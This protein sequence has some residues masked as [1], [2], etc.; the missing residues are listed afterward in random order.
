MTAQ[1]TSMRDVARAAGVS[2]ATVSY[3][4]NRGP[5]PVGEATRKRVMSAM[6]HVGYQVGRRGRA[7]TR[8]L[9]IGAIVADATNSFFSQALAGAESVL[10]K[11]GHILVAASSNDDAARELKALAAFSRA[12]VDGLI[13]TPRGDVPAE[14]ERLRSRGIPVVLMD[15]DGGSTELNRV[16]MDN[17]G[18]AFQATRLLIES[19][20]HRIALVNGP[21][22][23]STAR[24]RLR[25][26]RDA[27]EQA[28]LVF[29]E[30]YVRLG[31]FT[32]EH[33]R[34]STLDLLSLTP[35]PDAIFSSSVIL[36]T[37]VLW[38]LRARRVRWPEDIAVV[39]F[40]D[41]AWASLVTPTLTVVEQPARQ[42]GEVAAQLLMSASD[43][44]AQGQQLV[45]ESH[46]VLRESHRRLV[47]KALG[48]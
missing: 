18:S 41:A 38:S 32:F 27:L 7:R 30:K 9:T 24:E 43:G 45:L 25:G 40:G 3:V 20:H 37:G 33:G 22:S 13:L 23:I 10:S 8:S 1:H 26:Y 21:Q 4:V 12:R 47:G 34:Q 11:A 6:H 46:L 15:R 29:S 2:L 39:G 31:P 28:G 44:T 42:L 17:H 16:V 36:T 19:G 14:V 5:K 35:R 48:G